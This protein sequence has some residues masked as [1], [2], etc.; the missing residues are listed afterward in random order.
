MCAYN[1]YIGRLRLS[2]MYAKCI[3]LQSK[4][5]SPL[6]ESSLPD[7]IHIRLYGIK[8][9]KC[10]TI[11][12]GLNQSGC[13]K[14]TAPKQCGASHSQHI[15]CFSVQSLLATSHQVQALYHPSA[16]VR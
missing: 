1:L 10:S 7:E 16:E 12:N 5:Q 13:G 9:I 3:G 4:W 2:R 15:V 8:Q 14:A 11:T 6:I